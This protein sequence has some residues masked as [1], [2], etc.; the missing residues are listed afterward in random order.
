MRTN[1]SVRSR[2]QHSKNQTSITAEL[3]GNDTC[4]ALGVTARGHAPVLRLC[5]LL[6][7]GGLD[8]ARPLLVYRGET[9]A[10]RVR[11]IG[12]GAALTVR[13]STTDGRPRFARLNGDVRPP[14]RETARPLV[15]ERGEAARALG[16]GE[17]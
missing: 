10:L 17:P 15:E 11:M 7:E 5:R 16:G 14:V 4:T 3:I 8:P 6:V 2:A 9:L 12:E 13:Q 1:I